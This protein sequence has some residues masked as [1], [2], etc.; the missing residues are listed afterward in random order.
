VATGIRNIWGWLL[1][2]KMQTFYSGLEWLFITLFGIFFISALVILIFHCLRVMRGK[3]EIQRQG[4]LLLLGLHGIIY[5]SAIY[6]TM[7]FFDATTIFDNRMLLPVYVVALLFL[8][9]GVGALW[10]RGH[11]VSQRVIVISGL[12]VMGLALWNVIGTSSA[13]SRDGLGFID[14]HR[15]TSKTMEY[16]REHDMVLFYTNHP[17]TVYIQTGKSGYMVPSP[18]DTLTLQARTSYERDLAEM[19]AKI[20]A[21]DGFLVFF[22]EPDYETDPWYLDLTAGLVPMENLPDAIIWGRVE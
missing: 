18:L 16:I 13:L 11:Q 10:G 9:I 2:T 7:N 14:I 12:L 20:N 6:M 22:Y 1:P 15:R 4:L 5:L 17:P 8:L 19:K 21:Q 3:E